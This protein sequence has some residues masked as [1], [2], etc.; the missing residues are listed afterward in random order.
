MRINIVDDE[1]TELCTLQFDGVMAQL[2]RRCRSASINASIA[3]NI[4]ADSF[5]G[6]LIV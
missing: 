6:F 1:S 2:S 5:Y 3:H 4:V